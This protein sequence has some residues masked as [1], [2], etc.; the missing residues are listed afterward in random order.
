[1][2]GVS[3]K[4]VRVLINRGDLAAY[5]PTERSTRVR[6]GDVYAFLATR[7]IKPTTAKHKEDWLS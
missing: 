3:E 2:L 6:R 4:S 5:R 7:Q 1:M